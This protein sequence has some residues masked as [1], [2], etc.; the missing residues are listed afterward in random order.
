MSALDPFEWAALTGF[1]TWFLV[2]TIYQ[3]KPLK[4]AW[5][6]RIKSRD[7]FAMIPSWSFFAPNPGTNDLHLLYRD[8]FGDG[9]VTPWRQ[10]RIPTGP[11]RFV[12]NPSKRLQKGITDMSYTIQGY[13][14][15]QP[16]PA[17]LVLIHPA[18]LALLSFV[19]AQPHSPSAETTQFAIARSYGRH[20]DLDADLMFLS[21]FHRLR[22]DQERG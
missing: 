19:T 4:W 17:E 12:W 5:V 11:A 9:E 20:V 6:G 15:R 2:S 3:I 21:N 8:Q 10:V 13:A 16:K 7:Y 18:F 1:A 22:S 14:A